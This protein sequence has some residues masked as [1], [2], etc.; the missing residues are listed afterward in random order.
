MI[1][2]LYSSGMSLLVAPYALQLHYKHS[3]D[4]ILQVEAKVEHA[5]AK[6]PAPRSRG[7]L[8]A[9]ANLPFHVSLPLQ[10]L[11][12][13]ELLPGAEEIKRGPM[14]YV[15]PKAFFPQ[16]LWS[17]TPLTRPW[18]ASMPRSCAL[19]SVDRQ[20]LPPFIHAGLRTTVR[21]VLRLCARVSGRLINVWRRLSV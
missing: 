8:L 2:S 20:Q 17:T 3:S 5:R 19:L 11:V 7:P 16:I 9:R 10:N 15:E 18:H 6:H 13:A 4:Q 1:K 12:L 21:T 14:R